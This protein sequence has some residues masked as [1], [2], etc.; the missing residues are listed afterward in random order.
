MAGMQLIHALKAALGRV[1]RSGRLTRCAG[2]AA[3]AGDGAGGD[4]PGYYFHLAGMNPA[5]NAAADPAFMSAALAGYDSCGVGPN[6]P[7]AG[8]MDEADAIISAAALRW[9]AGRRGAGTRRMPP[10]WKAGSSGAGRDLNGE[11]A[12]L[13]VSGNRRPAM[14]KS[15]LLPCR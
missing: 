5:K 14:P 15:T 13:I 3:A 4:F 7:R 6:S 10:L 2:P 9:F 12:R 11:S 8:Q 1:W